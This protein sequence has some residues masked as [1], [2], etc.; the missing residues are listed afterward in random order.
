MVAARLG[1]MLVS[2]DRLADAFGA[3]FPELHIANSDIEH[4]WPIEVAYLGELVKAGIPFVFD[5]SLGIENALGIAPRRAV[6]IVGLGYP[7][8]T[9]EEKLAQVR[10]HDADS[11]WT[12][13]AGDVELLDFFKRHIIFSHLRRKECRRHGLRFVDTSSDW[14]R[15]LEET[16]EA[17]C[18]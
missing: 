10:A 3:I 12:R 4:L 11:D 1:R 16:C 15:A 8:I 17:L 18:L 13:A 2:E 7:N 14:D 9:A 5:G 6:R